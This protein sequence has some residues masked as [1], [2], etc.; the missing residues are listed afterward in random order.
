MADVFRRSD[1]QDLIEHSG[2]P[3]V[4]ILFPTHRAGGDAERQDPLR[5]RNL[6]DEAER[7]L[8]ARGLRGPDASALL[9]PGRDLLPSGHFWSYQGDGLALYLAPGW[10]RVYRL[11]IA[12]PET[13]VV[14]ERCYVKPLFDLLFFDRRFFVLALSQNDARLLEASRQWVQ[15]INLGDTPRSLAEVLR[16]DDLEPQ[17]NLHIASR[18]GTGAQAVFH[19]HGSGGEVDRVLHERWARA[20]S[21]GV[22][23]ILH[24]ERE[25]L[26]LAGVGYERVL[27]RAATRYPLVLEEGIEGNPE[28]LSPAELQERA[29]SIIEPLLVGEREAAA[30]RFL[31]AVGRGARAAS[32]IED[33]VQAAIEGRVDQLFVPV[34]VH[35]WG[36][37]DPVAHKVT[38]TDDDDVDGCEDLLDR[39]AVETVLTA[40]TVHVVPAQDVPGP[41]PA[42]AVLRY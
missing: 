5:L 20:L 32:G 17:Q 34:G 27:F 35:V 16:Y 40:G 15:S 36:T 25:P 42:A 9:A 3:V 18:G 6:L 10:S 24:G 31:E 28:L 11:P 12:V 29:W 37:I 21:R 23:Q 33:V 22:E 30:A 26:V 41:G 13:V 2:G 8:I 7:Q 39:A 38:L 19:G 1:V 4:S 14:A